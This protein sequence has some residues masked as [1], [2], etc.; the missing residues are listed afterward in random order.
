MDEVYVPLTLESGGYGRTYTS[1]NLLEAG[2]RLLIMGDP[3]SGKSTLVKKVYRDTCRQT[4]EKPGQ[5]RLPILRDLKNLNPPAHL[6]VERDLAEWLLNE[7]R[8]QVAQVEGFEMA[9]LF[10]TWL[11]G[12]GLF[13]LLDGMDEVA[14]DRYV[15]VAT[16]LR[17]LSQRLSEKSPGNAVVVTMRVQF[18][19]QVRADLLEDYPK[20]LYVRPF[21]PN[22]IFL[23][24]QRWPFA[25]DREKNANRVYRELNDRPTLRD[26]CGNPLVLAMYT[27]RDWKDGNGKIP[28]SRTE[29]YSRVVEELLVMRRQR[30]IQHPGRLDTEYREREAFLGRLALEHLMD[31]DQ[32]ANSLDWK[33]ALVLGG[34]TWKCSEVEAARRLRQLASVTGIISEERRGESYRFI[35]LTFCE[36]LAAKECADGEENGWRR[37]I[38]RHRAFRDSLQ[39]QNRTRLSGTLPFAHALLRRGQKPE[40]AL[41]DVADLGD[42]SVLGQCFLET[43][44]YET[45]QWPEYFHAERNDLMENEGREWDEARLRQLHAFSVVVRDAAEWAERTERTPDPDLG[46]VFEK[47]VSGNR[48]RLLTI[49]TSHASQD[50]AAAFSLA[51]QAGPRSSRGLSGK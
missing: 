2:G 14:S 33:R 44:L 30:Q 48:E 38:D 21:S 35:H 4:A 49:F 13:V 17:G 8:E 7:L 15:K 41:A 26:L 19:Q 24:L 51:D 36:F 27:Q 50:A 20:T 39:V 9:E 23:F 46:T 16:A 29:F 45:R 28:E 5:G 11:S 22:E 6:T 12:P 32:P 1:L 10:D 25:S 40:K 34:Q 3:G 47:I 43:Q 42:R 37:L 18:Y 31:P